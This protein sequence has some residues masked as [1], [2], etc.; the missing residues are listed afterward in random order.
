MP[1]RC[2]ALL[3]CIVSTIACAAAA[4]QAA[5]FFAESS[6]LIASPRT[7]VNPFGVGQHLQTM[8]AADPESADNL[9]VCGAR[10][11]PRTGAAYEGYVYQSN[12]RGRT[13]IEAWVDANSRWV[14]EESCTF[15]EGH[16]AYF[17]ASAS[18]T[19]TGLLLHEYG[20]TRLYRSSDG[21]R[22]WQTI[23]VD[24]FMD[25]TSMAVDV[26]PGP[27]RGTVYIF[28]NDVADG[29]G[30][31]LPGN[32]PYLG[33]RREFPKLDFSVIAGNWSS[34][35][36]GGIYP[37][38]TVVLSDGTLISVYWAKKSIKDASGKEI[39]LEGVNSYASRDGGK[40]LEGPVTLW[41]EYI[42]SNL[43]VNQATD[44]LFVAFTARAQPEQKRTRLSEFSMPEF[45]AA[46]GKLM[47][48]TSTD[49]GRTWSIHPVNPPAGASLDIAFLAA[50][51]IAVNKEGVMGFLWYGQGRHPA[52]FGVSRDGGGSISE[53]MRL[54]PDEPA[55]AVGEKF[56]IDSALAY[57]TA[58][59]PQLPPYSNALVADIAG[60]FH[61]LWC[62]RSNGPIELYTQ[63]ISLKGNHP[64]KASL[65]R[66]GLT[67]VTD[68]VLV[69]EQ[70]FR[71]DHLGRLYAY[72]VAVSNRSSQALN[73]P[74]LAVLPEVKLPLAADNADDGQAHG[75]AT[76]RL[77]SPS[78][79]LGPGQTTDP[80]AFTFRIEGRL[81]ED[82]FD[83]GIRPP[84]IKI[85]ARV[86]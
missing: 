73:G 61:P 62:E 34:D 25:F 85:Y 33:I 28:A 31:D 64:G 22:T 5:T 80:R 37:Q 38:G 44:Q 70:N 4:A 75:A 12:D 48:A 2:P 41:N 23:Q 51:S 9:I 86:P 63:M 77:F 50:P 27:N 7:P 84:E 53:L 16:R 24:H 72:D 36:M 1:S 59:S 60:A 42:L 19:S 29:R 82:R 46:Q 20:S 43:A 18:N 55:G 65:R 30:G 68:R 78:G 11:N 14:T 54:T 58:S 8:V 57:A 40:T 67:D 21:G 32:R 81:D 3:L 17:L 83:E 26:R 35:A 79:D 6:T 47:L 15:G 52:F 76:W 45:L 66:T 13:W 71:F 39:S 56:Y 69:R 10:M 74:I 49:Q